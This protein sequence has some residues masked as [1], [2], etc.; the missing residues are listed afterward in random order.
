MAETGHVQQVLDVAV[1]TL[2]L[3]AGAFEQ[4]ATIRQRD[5]LT[6]RQQAVDAATHGGQRRAQIVG[7]R[8]QQGAAQLL[9]LA[10]QA[11][12]FEVL[13][14]LR[15]GQ[16]LGQRPAE[17]RQPAPT[18]AAQGAVVFRTH[19]QQRQRSTFHRQRPPPPAPGRQRPGPGAGRLV[20]LPGPVG[21]R[22]FGLGERQ[23]LGGLDLPAT[24]AISIEQ[25]QLQVVPAIEVLRSGA[26]HRLAVGGSR[27][28]AGQIEQ[29]ASF[30]L[31][32]T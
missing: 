25:A 9:G 24:L 2:G 8:G 11:R 12:R 32:V 5:R 18:L 19:A 16:R 23:R 17:G 21:R 4:F 28:L 27:E 10:V 22:A 30:L 7:H 31:G 3:I 15:P 6:Q 20:V 14:Q 13:S 26:D 29:F 1:Q